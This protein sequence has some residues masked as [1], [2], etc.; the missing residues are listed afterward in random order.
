MKS[1]FIYNVVM[2][3]AIFSWPLHQKNF[4]NEKY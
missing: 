2:N 1:K 4:S 3:N